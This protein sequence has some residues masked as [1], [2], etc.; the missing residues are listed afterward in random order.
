MTQD[1]H[2]LFEHYRAKTDARTAWNLAV[3]HTVLRWVRES[4]PS[5]D[6]VRAVYLLL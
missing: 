4:E 1:A 5:E 3:V 2:E 6:D